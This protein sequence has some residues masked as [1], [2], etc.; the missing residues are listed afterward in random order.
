MVIWTC[1]VFICLEVCSF[2]L[3][4]LL[5]MVLLVRAEIISPKIWILFDLSLFSMVCVT[6]NP[7]KSDILPLAGLRNDC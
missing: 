2:F 3:F 4:R 6:G 5:F 7:S 1:W